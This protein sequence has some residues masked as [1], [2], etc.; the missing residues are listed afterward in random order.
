VGN[1]GGQQQAAVLT[2]APVPAVPVALES[3]APGWKGR[4]RPRWCLRQCPSPTLAARKF[5]WFISQR[6]SWLW[7]IGI[8]NRLRPAYSCLLS[9]S[10][11]KTKAIC[12]HATRSPTAR[13]T[14]RCFGL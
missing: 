1:N 5:V 3:A 7:C 8:Y 10:N 13:P 9:K 14:A 2:F 12:G 4:W 6:G 11:N